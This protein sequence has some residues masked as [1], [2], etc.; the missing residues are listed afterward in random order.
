MKT[1]FVIT[2]AIVGLLAVGVAATEGDTQAVES[3]CRTACEGAR[4]EICEPAVQATRDGR[5]TEEKAGA[6][7]QC[8][9]DVCTAVCTC[10]ANRETPCLRRV[11]AECESLGAGMP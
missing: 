4:A 5:M 9:V 7:C 10:E 3:G 11:S 2:I 8:G 6:L 1:L